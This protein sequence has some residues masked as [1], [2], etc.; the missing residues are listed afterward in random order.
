[1]PS[2]KI[3]C[4]PTNLASDDFLLPSAVCAAFHAALLVLSVAVF[5]GYQVRVSGQSHV[6]SGFAAALCV[7]CLCSLVLEA[8]V[9]AF[10]RRGTSNAH[11]LD[12]IQAVLP[13]RRGCKCP[14]WRQL[15]LGA[16]EMHCSIRC[17]IT[18]RSWARPTLP[19]RHAWHGVSMFSSIAVLSSVASCWSHR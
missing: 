3:L 17:C 1:M 2:I 13:E 14:L 9:F 16:A 18:G 4:T 5:V 8:A 10:T 11:V 12:T 19:G 15:V 6:P 7:L